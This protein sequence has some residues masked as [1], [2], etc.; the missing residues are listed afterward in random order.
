MKT[1]SSTV[2]LYCVRET[3]GLLTIGAALFWPAG[4]FAWWQ[5]WAVLADTLAWTVGM[6]VVI[7]IY[8]P[9]LLAERLGPRPNAKKWDTLIMSFLG[10]LQL[11]RYILARFDHKLGWS[12]SFPLWLQVTAAGLCLLA[13]GLVVWAAGV[14]A[15]FTQIVRIQEERGQTVVKDGPYRLIRHP[16]YLGAGLVEITV[17]V[18]LGSWWAMSI[19]VVTLILLLL[20]TSLED[21]MLRKDLPGYEEFCHQTR[22]RLIPGVW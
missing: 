22:F 11:V 17:P 7:L 8:N 14:N 15:F 1:R 10:I 5:A 13:Y 21:K 20:R 12:G 18:L 4:T 3:L 9:S 2:V 19:S 16:A 6:G